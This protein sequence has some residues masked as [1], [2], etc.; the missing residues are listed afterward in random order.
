MGFVG[1]MRRSLSGQLNIRMHVCCLSRSSKNTPALHSLIVVFFFFSPNEN[2][3]LCKVTHLQMFMQS[4][5]Q[6]LTSDS[7]PSASPIVPSF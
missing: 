4:L 5:Q 1:L 7:P 6:H 2:V 3:K